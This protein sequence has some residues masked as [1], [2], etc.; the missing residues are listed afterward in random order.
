MLTRALV[1]LAALSVPAEAQAAGYVVHRG[2]TLSAIA[3]QSHV[4]VYALAQANGLTN[5]NMVR[6]GQVLFIPAATW[7][8][9][10]QAA[11]SYGY[12]RSAWSSSASVAQPAGAAV[13][14]YSA[15]YGSYRVQWGDTLSG[16]ALRFHTTVAALRA[17]NPSLGTYLI[18][19]Q[20]LSLCTTC[21][22]SSVGEC[23]NW[24]TPPR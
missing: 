21:A 20:A 1:A 16:L 8:Y 12:S 5:P 18:A 4:S 13:T 6:A 17:S 22:S 19:G 10:Y 3:Q 15:S 7:G 2:D 9:G 23:R 11:P 24:S 14:A